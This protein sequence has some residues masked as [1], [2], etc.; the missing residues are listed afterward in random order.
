MKEAQFYQQLG[1]C[2]L[3]LYGMQ[4]GGRHMQKWVSSTPYR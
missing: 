1:K 4:M 3:K 2:T